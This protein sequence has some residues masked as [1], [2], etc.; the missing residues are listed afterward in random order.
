MTHTSILTK[1]AEQ[2]ARRRTKKKRPKMK[3]SGGENKKLVKIIR[4]K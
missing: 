3:V 2:K 1:K 4:K